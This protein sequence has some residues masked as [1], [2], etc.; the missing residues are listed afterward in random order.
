MI[1]IFRKNA[2]YDFKK[3]YEAML[4]FLSASTAKELQN[5]DYPLILCKFALPPRRTDKQ[6]YQDFGVS[7]YEL[8]DMF[9]MGVSFSDGRRTNL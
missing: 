3:N 7:G 4:E 2:L 9:R 1:R 6:L 5:L 8:V